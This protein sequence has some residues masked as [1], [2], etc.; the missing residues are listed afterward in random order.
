MAY[1]TFTKLLSGIL[2]IKTVDRVIKVYLT[3]TA[4]KF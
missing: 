1:L 3:D 4:R 2:G